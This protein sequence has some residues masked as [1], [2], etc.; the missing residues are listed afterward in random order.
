MHG[1]RQLSC[2]SS[3][4][5]AVPFGFS[6][7]QSLRQHPPAGNFFFYQLGQCLLSLTILHLHITRE[8]AAA[9]SSSLSV[10]ASSTT[11][12]R[13]SIPSSIDIR[14][15]ELGGGA[16]GVVTVAYTVERPGS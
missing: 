12:S 10:T 11:I 6:R 16:G 5:A 2:C 1:S 9:A 14:V 4:R 15:C 3:I 8:L 13:Y 7:T